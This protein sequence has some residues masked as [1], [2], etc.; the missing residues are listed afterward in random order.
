[1]AAPPSVPTPP[2]SRGLSLFDR[3]AQLHAY[4]TD[5]SSSSSSTTNLFDKPTFSSK[6]ITSAPIIYRGT[7]QNQYSPLLAHHRSPLS[8]SECH[9]NSNNNNNVQL[10]GI[11]PRP[12]STYIKEWPSPPPLPAKRS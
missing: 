2:K 4:D 5:K 11:H 9:S 8:T 1:M 12:E 3:Q 7:Q 10:I 6:P